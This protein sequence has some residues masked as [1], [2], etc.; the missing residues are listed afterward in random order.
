MNQGYCLVSP[1]RPRSYR[2]VI[3]LEYLE[4]MIISLRDVDL[5]IKSEETI[6]SVCPSWVARVSKVF[7]S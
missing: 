3:I 2:V 6:V 1:K 4:S 5:A 7:L